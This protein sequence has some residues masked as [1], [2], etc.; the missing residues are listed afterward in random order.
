MYCVVLRT[1]SG[2]IFEDGHQLLLKFESS[3]GGVE[4]TFYTRYAD[5]GVGCLMPVGLA[6]EVRGVAGRICTAA[7]CYY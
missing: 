4:V 6:I 1:P 2:V 5:R 3:E 7:L